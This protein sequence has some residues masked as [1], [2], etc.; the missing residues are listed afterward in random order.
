MFPISVFENSLVGLENRWSQT[1]AL[2]WQSRKQCS[3]DSWSV[4]QT[5][6]RGEV[7]RCLLT[8]S[9]FVSKAECRAFQINTRILSRPAHFQ[10]SWASTLREFLSTCRRLEKADFVKNNPSVL[11][12]HEVIFLRICTRRRNIRDC[13]N[14]T[15][16]S[17]FT[18]FVMVPFPS[19]V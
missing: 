2:L 13:I 7:A 8:R 19:L 12:P 4:P 14:Y 3:K 18:Q 9:W 11:A 1:V 6:Q 15:W 5:G 16:H 10:A 17:Q